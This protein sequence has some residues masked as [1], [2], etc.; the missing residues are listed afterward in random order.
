MALVL[1]KVRPCDGQCC[2]ESPR[3]PNRNGTDCIY[4]TDETSG[5]DDTVRTG[6]AFGCALMRDVET[7]KLDEMSKIFVNEKAQDVFKRT[8][9]D[10]PQNTRPTVSIDGITGVETIGTTGGCCWQWVEDGL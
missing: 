1:Q 7:I 4:R 2:K 10:W 6:A 8:C 3:F 5:K 9:V